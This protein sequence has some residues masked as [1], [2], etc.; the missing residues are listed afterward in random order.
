M[1]RFILTLTTKDR[2]HFF[3]IWIG[4]IGGAFLSIIDS[5]VTIASLGVF[6]SSLAITFI[7]ALNRIQIRSYEKRTKTL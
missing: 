1:N 5:I 3:L 2:P 4:W 7:L 6:H